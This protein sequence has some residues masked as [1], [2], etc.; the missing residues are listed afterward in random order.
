MYDALFRS[1]P[2]Q[3]AVPN[4]PSG[5]A[6]EIGE[7]LVDVESDHERLEGADRSELDV[8]PA[9]D[10]E[11]EAV[12]LELVAGVGAHDDVCEGIVR[13]RVHSV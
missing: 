1:E 9:P 5:E 6:T 7:R 13:S 11:G 10:R 3:R 12:P 8:V 2:A 4:Q